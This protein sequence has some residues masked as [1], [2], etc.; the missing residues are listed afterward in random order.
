MDQ[1]LLKPEPPWTGLPQ[2]VR[3]LATKS[4]SIPQD[5][6]VVPAGRVPNQVWKRL[7]PVGQC[8]QCGHSILQSTNGR[9]FCSSC[10]YNPLKDLEEK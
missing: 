1:G 3:P 7:V 9:Q 2:V 6:F 5:T 4:V 8:P 10:N